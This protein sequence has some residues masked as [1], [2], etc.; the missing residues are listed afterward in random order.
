MAD[1]ASLEHVHE[2]RVNP[3]GRQLVFQS[4]VSHTELWELVNFLP[5]AMMGDG[6]QTVARK[7]P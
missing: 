1:L 5:P 3:N 2:I 4:V 7:V 6:K